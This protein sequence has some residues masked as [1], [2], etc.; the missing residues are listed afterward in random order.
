[1]KDLFQS[2][3]VPRG[4]RTIWRY[5]GALFILFTLGIGQMWADV[6]YYTPTADEVIILNDV[7]SSTATTAGYSSH[8]AVSWAN[9]GSSMT[10]SKYAGDPSKSTCSAT[11]SKVT[12]YSV[13]GNSGKKDITINIT[14]C[15]KIVVY[16][17]SHP[18]R[19]VELRSG[20]K[21]GSLIAQSEASTYCTEVD[22][23]GSTSYS[24]FLHGIDN[25][26][27]A[28]FYVYAVKLIKATGGSTKYTVTA[29]T[30]TGTDS[31]GTV[32]AGASELAAGETTTITAVPAT[33][34]K[35]SSWAV[36]GTGATIDPS[37]ASNTTTLTMG[38]ANATVTVYFTSAT[39]YT[40]NR[41]LTHVTATS[42]ANAVY[43]GNDYS[44]VFAADE[45][46]VLPDA[47]TVMAGSTNI[48][49]ACTWNSTTGALTV[50]AASI[51]GHLTI[52]I[53][54][55]DASSGE[56]PVGN[57]CDKKLYYVVNVDKPDGF[58][59]TDAF[60]FN[61][62]FGTSA[63]SISG[64]VTIDD[65]NYSIT[66]QYQISAG[67]NVV[68]FVVPEGKKANFY[69]ITGSSG[70]TRT[71]TIAC[72]A[73]SYSNTFASGT[74]SVGASCA[75]SDLASG[76]YTLSWSGGALTFGFL[77]LELCDLPTHSVTIN[78]N[79][80]SYASTPDGWTLSAGVYT[81]SVAVG[82]FSAPAGLTNGTKIL[83]WADNHDNEITFPITLDKDTV[84]VAQWTAPVTKYTVAY[85]DGSTKL[86]EEEVEE[87][88]SPV[89]YATY[90]TKELHSFSNWKNNADAVIVPASL[91]VT[92]DTALYGNW[93][94]LYVADDASFDFQANTTLGDITVSTTKAE[95]SGNVGNMLFS[96]M[97]IQYGASSEGDYYGWKIKKA[98]GTIRFYVQNDRRLQI[99]LGAAGSGAG[100][101]IT[102]TV[103]GGAETNA[104]LVNNSTNTYNVAAGTLVTLTTKNTTNTVTLQSIA[105]DNIPALDDDATLSDLKVGGVTVAGFSA[106][107]NTYYYGVPYGTAVEDFP[108]ISATANSTKALQV[109]IQQAVWAGE[110]YNCYRAQANVQAQDESWGYYDVRFYFAPKYG[111]EL[112]KA[113]HDGTAA[114]ADKDGYWKDDVTVDKFTQNGGK[115]G[116]ADHYF[117]LT[118]GGGK[119]FKAGDL[120]VIK[121]SNISS[122]VELFDTKTFASKEDSLSY[123]NKG[124][125]DTHSKMYTFTLTADADKLY[126]Y[127]TK[128]ANSQMN[129]TV[130]YIAVYR[131]MAPFIEEFKIGDDYAT[132]T[133]KAIALELPHGT[134]LTGVAATVKAYANGGATV[135]APAALA[136]NTPL[137]YTVKGAYAEDLTG[138]YAPVDY[139]LT[140]TEAPAIKEVVVSGT[141]TVKEDETTALSAVVYDT[142][143]EEAANQNVTWSVK[144]GDESLASVDASGVVTGKAAGTAHIIATSVADGDIF[145]QVEVVVTENPCRAWSN[146]TTKDEER[147]VGKMKVTPTNLENLQEN[148]VPY[149]GATAC[150]AWKLNSKDSRY[151]EIN[152][153]DNAQFEG[154]TLGVS[155]KDSNK[156]YQFA[157]VCSSKSGDNFADG[158]LSAATYEAV[159]NDEPEALVDVELATGTKAVRVYR[160]VVVGTTTYGGGSSVFLYYINACKK[161]LV[162]VTSVALADAK[163]AIDRSTTPVLTINPELADVASIVWSIVGEG[164][165]TIAT[166]NATTGEVSGLA[167]GT[168]TVKAVVTDALA[169]VYNATA[170]VTVIT[171]YEQVNVTGSITWNW[172]N[173][174]ANVQKTD[175]NASGVM[176]NEGL[177]NDASFNSQA[178]W[179]Q[180][181]RPNYV[182]GVTKCAQ[183]Y[184]LKFHTTV[185]GVLTVKYSSNGSTKKAVKVGDFTGEYSENGGGS[186]GVNAL[187]E[188][189]NIA[190][191]KDVLIEGV[192]ANGNPAEVRIFMMD[193]NTNFDIADADYT[194]DVTAGRFGTICLENGGVMTGATLY[195]VAYY[196]QTS[197]KI[198]FDEILDGTMVAGVPYIYLPNDDAEQLGVFY[199]DNA[200]APATSAN[201]L[202]GYIAATETAADA[203]EVPIGSYIL[204][205]NQYRKVVYAQSAYILSHRAYINLDAINPSEPALAP[206]R[207]RIS[208]S[209]QQTEVATDIDNVQGDDAQCTKVLINGQMYIL[210]GEKMYD[211]TG[212][213]VK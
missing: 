43:E 1:M 198:F 35:V 161:E 140:L 84:L 47:I 173:A 133:D 152:F 116:S 62:S 156:N 180:G 170:T 113:T 143:D 31:Y 114:G 25:N 24:I 155:S 11:G 77:A 158:I 164:D 203:L 32:S 46:Y 125:F 191:N 44:A 6:S 126:L 167:E 201:G 163:V 150:N 80:G 132:I 19:L 184:K 211:A 51:N 7:H 192:L 213:L 88:A 13:K 112:I 183:V 8:A 199:T 205:G 210:R 64:S 58:T 153:T 70:S 92:Q 54:G 55:V 79:G 5:L 2:K 169:S 200:N 131:Y 108:V 166:I 21:T 162:P 4:P 30:S 94:K 33:G 171:E 154:L 82:S 65:V 130:E 117:G 60:T 176:A 186:Q 174:G 121:A 14:G 204:S 115:L 148:M 67:T 15:S 159:D 66:K 104:T 18:S 27:D 165:G 98:N 26:N 87:N 123:L 197:K 129:P 182:N 141:L 102:Y 189:F 17:E 73:I 139:T 10:A 207:R 86:G 188:T 72:S 57:G 56:D 99:T 29:Q 40:V 110:P 190:A 78:P 212:R 149:Q 90:Q 68:S 118:L 142:N 196:G 147:T 42:G 83:S 175:G 146:P 181:S 177:T 69:A 74:S 3:P 128:T 97:D 105:L 135:V 106:G 23:T 206:G 81:K 95:V 61:S 208:M 160:Q 195:E 36:S 12:G 179:Y 157:V 185:A 93:A 124:N 22:L 63:K 145:A 16:H 109:A 48:T 134:N 96:K 37:G 91:V 193:F 76:T 107:T 137:V 111:V 122:T 178:L 53:A 120:V 49:A 194:R 151:A 202:V 41:S 100:F 209:V 138:D 52:T 172:A 89:S 119:T 34:Y 144:A 168:V 136:F 28:D 187:T 9:S 103:K 85:Y 50:P 59:N 75:I 127:R 45:G 20:S 101:D 71:V 38:T 39:S